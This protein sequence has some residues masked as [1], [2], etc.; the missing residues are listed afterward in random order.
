MPLLVHLA[1]ASPEAAHFS[2][3]RAGVCTRG[4]CAPFNFALPGALWS[5]SRRK[6][7]GS[8]DRPTR[9]VRKRRDELR[10]FEGPPCWLLSGELGRRFGIPFLSSWWC[11]FLSAHLQEPRKD[12]KFKGTTIFTTVKTECWNTDLIHRDT[13]MNI[14]SEYDTCTGMSICVREHTYFSHKTQ[15]QKTSKNIF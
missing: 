7:G 11:L 4:T 14:N 13:H 8:V 2:P 6:E 9:V 1:S 3:G 5:R 15:I 12:E 10:A